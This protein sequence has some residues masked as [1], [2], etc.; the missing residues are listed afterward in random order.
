MSE[1]TPGDWQPGTERGTVVSRR[2][3][4]ASGIFNPADIPLIAAAKRTAE[5]RDQLLA[6]CGVFLADIDA[7]GI[8][9]LLPM[10]AAIVKARKS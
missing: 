7:G 6:V 5:E 1:P 2:L 8:I 10:R 9:D 3:R 4:V